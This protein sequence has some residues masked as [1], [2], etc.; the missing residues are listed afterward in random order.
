MTAICGRGGH[1]GLIPRYF[2][3]AVMGVQQGR[4]NSTVYLG[5]GLIDSGMLCGAYTQHCMGHC[6]RGR[7]SM[8]SVT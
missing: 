6:S 5:G 1:K 4:I 8:P 7:G 3:V 2:Y